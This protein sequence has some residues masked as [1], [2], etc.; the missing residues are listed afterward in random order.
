MTE[1]VPTVDLAA[2]VAAQRARRHADTTH[3]LASAAP[4]L[5][6]T[7]AQLDTLARLHADAAAFYATQLATDTPTPV[8]RR[9][10]ST[11]AR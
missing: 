7:A 8:R 10:R 6:V 5:L 11:S 9:G 1:P 2:I 4:G 3:A